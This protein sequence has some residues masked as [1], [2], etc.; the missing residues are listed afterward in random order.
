MIQINFCY[1]LMSNSIQ[2]DIGMC[3]IC[4]LTSFSR[5]VRFPPSFTAFLFV[6]ISNSEKMLIIATWVTKFSWEGYKI[7]CRF[8]KKLGI[9]LENKVS[10]KVC[11]DFWPI[12]LILYPS[13][14]K[15]TTHIAIMLMRRHCPARSFLPTSPQVW[16]I[17]CHS[18]KRW[19]FCYEPETQCKQNLYHVASE[20]SW[21]LKRDTYFLTYIFCS[22]FDT[23]W[24]KRNLSK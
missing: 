17:V 24:I 4:Y 14:R 16:S 18:G 20:L 3:A 6:K 21:P 2:Y 1:L 5:S 23:V 12:Y 13:L 19:K 9:I 10:L 8:V 11:V 7:R 22:K 15:L